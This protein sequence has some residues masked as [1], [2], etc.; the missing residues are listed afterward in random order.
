MTSTK[1]PK[2]EKTANREIAFIDSAVSDIETLTRGLRPGLAAIR[3]DA[4]APAVA[5]IARALAGQNALDAIHVIAHGAPGEVCFATGKLSLDTIDEHRSS[6][7]AIGRALGGDGDLLLWSCDSGQGGRGA[8]FVAALARVT[9]AEVAAATSLVGAASRGGRWALAQCAGDVPAPAP[10][11]AA[12]IMAY[13]GVMDTGSATVIN[14]N[15]LDTSKTNDTGGVENITLAEVGSALFPTTNATQTLTVDAAFWTNHI[16]LT[17]QG[18][19]GAYFTIWATSQNNFCIALSDKYGSVLV[20]AA[21]PFIAA[22]A[23]DFVTKVSNYSSLISSTSA[24]VTVDIEG[25]ANKDV[26]QGIANNAAITNIIQGGAGADVLTGG[27]GLNIYVY[28]SASDSPVAGQPNS[29]G[30]LAQSWDQI[31]NF[32]EGVD[33]LDFRG[34]AKAAGLPE[35]TWVG[36]LPANT[37]TAAHYGV[38]YTTDGSGGSYVYVDTNGDGTADL[39][40]QVAGVPTLTSADFLLDPPVLT[41]NSIAG[42]DMINKVEAA[43]GVTISGKEIGADGQTVTVKI[44]DSGGGVIGTYTTMSGS[45]IWSVNV[46]AAQAQTLVDGRYTV[47]AVVNTLDNQASA[48]PR[49]FTVDTAA[50]VAANLAITYNATNASV[51]GDIN[52]A[53][54]SAT[55]FTVAGLDAD[56]SAT[57]TFSGI[58][59]SN[60]LAGTVVKT[61]STNGSSTADLS[62]FKDG[63][64]T[65]AISATD[66]AGN[67]ASDTGASALLDT[68][69]DVG[70]DLQVTVPDASINNSEKT[71]VAY[72]V[73][74]LDPDAT[75]TVKFSD[76]MNTVTGLGGFADLT[77][78]TDGPITVSISTTE[79]PP[80]R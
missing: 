38:W 80:R 58:L 37:T 57:V 45:G 31:T 56:A 24:L 59:K 76:G 30:Q 53:H 29:G 51:A 68:T 15:I 11:T 71:A 9:G 60:N 4:S 65:A 54:A 22:S 46:T 10:L 70:G 62:V 32:H 74:G 55:S 61:A 20:P 77:S 23:S 1:N 43:A 18:S 63:T 27:S 14:L 13:Q 49:S 67:T 5:Q 2:I 41:I 17:F 35:L 21:T 42:D 52:A 44:L 6:L 34:I 39:K 79:T 47:T 3:L 50:D 66:T 7:A 36:L 26:V 25:G 48:T 16:Q 28:T 40:L 33:K 73:L 75:A 64:I 78:L 72:T 69:A 8:A 19:G 12:G